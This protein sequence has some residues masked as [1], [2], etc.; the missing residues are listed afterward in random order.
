MA[1]DKRDR[2]V[3]SEQAL[4]AARK[5]ESKL[6]VALATLAIIAALAL[7]FCDPA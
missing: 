5:R 1:R 6:H 2:P 4:A 3:Y 7:R